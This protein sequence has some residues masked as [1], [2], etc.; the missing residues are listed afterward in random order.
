MHWN[1]VTL[2][3]SLSFKFILCCSITLTIALGVSFYIIAKQQE[4]LIMEQ[5]E[6]EARALFKHIVIT[7]KWVSDHQGVFVE[8]LPWVKE[9]P[10]LKDI[11]SEI[12][13][14]KG[15][16]YVRK[17]PAMVTR[18]LS[19]YAGE[20][21]LFWFHITSLKLLNPENAP[22]EFE[23]NALFQFE[24]NQS[25]EAIS[26]TP[27]GNSKYLRYIS[28][29]YIEESCLRCHAHQGYKIGDI[30]GAI[31]ITIPVDKTFAHIEANRKNMLI[32]GL[33]TLSSLIIAM[34]ILLRNLIL[35]PMSKLKTSVEEFSGGRYLP[36]ARLKT[37]DEFE[38]LSASFSNMVRTL[39]EYHDILNDK[40]KTATK[41]LEEKNTKLVE[42][43]KLLKE[44]D[45][46]KSDFIARASHELRTPLTSIKGAID[47][48][49]AR[50]SLISEHKPEYEFL[51][52]VSMFLD[53]IKNNSERLIR[54]VNDMLDLERIEMGKSEIHPTDVNPSHIIK[55]TLTYFHLEAEKRN[56]N[57]ISHLNSDLSICVDE[58][59]IKQVLT[60]LLANALKFSPDNSEIKITAYP[61]DNF[62]VIS[63]CDQGIGIPLSKQDLIFDKFVKYGNKEGSGLGLAICRSIIE[64]HGGT[65]YVE[66]DG[67]KGSCFF[68]K[69]PL[70]E[71]ANK[72]ETI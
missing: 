47:Y 62:L 29:L 48:I 13:D 61:E 10:Y 66:S 1:T 18:E 40:I 67:E 16:K 64:A 38:E 28:P 22:D 5:I 8:K 59:R 11:E 17:N 7:R 19:E 27:I 70:G 58:D 4:R 46:R 71:C 20:K 53:I 63:V 36:I 68:F 6:F 45:I 15:R 14:I 3:L 31:S 26:V 49:N 33:L 12:V 55:E 30:R 2:K 50:L 43:N 35:K 42:M 54:M 37:G 52:D 69:L 32:A 41:D 34:I 57:I 39:S 60:N 44:V 56:I 72:K 21:G 25:N 24:N 9:N 65:I 51:N 23:K